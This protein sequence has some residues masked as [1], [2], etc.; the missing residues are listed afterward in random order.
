MNIKRQGVGMNRSAVAVLLFLFILSTTLPGAA[1]PLKIGNDVPLNNENPGTTEMGALF[2]DFSQTFMVRSEPLAQVVADLNNDSRPDVAVIY[3]DSKNLDIFFC[4]QNNNFSFTNRTS[5]T[6]TYDLTALTA[7]YMDDDDL[8]DLVVASNYTSNNVAILYQKNNFALASGTIF[9][10]NLRPHALV[11][12]DFDGDTHLDVVTLFSRDTTSYDPGF[13]IHFYSDGYGLGGVQINL[14]SLN[15]QM[16]RLMISGDFNGD[17]L[18]D[19]IIGDHGV[20]RVVGYING[21]PDGMSWTA[22]TSFNIGGP[23]DL[24]LE[25]IDGAGLL[26]LAVCADGDSQIKFYHFSS[27]SFALVTLITDELMP[28]SLAVIDH[29]GDSRLDVVR[30]STQY[31]N[32][33][34]FDT[35]ATYPY[36]YSSS[37]SFPTPYYPVDVQALDMNSD[38]ESDL[39]VI[40]RSSSGN[41]TVTIY[42]QNSITVSNANDNQLIKDV[43]PS[44]ATIGDFNGDGSNEVAVYD[45]SAAQ[46]KVRF[47]DGSS[48]NLEQRN[49]P[50]NVSYLRSTDL[51]GDGC[52]E[53]IMTVLTP[54]KAWVWFGSSTFMIGGGSQ[55]DITS[56]GLTQASSVTFG[57]LDNDTD[58][59]LA[60]GGTGGVD[61]FWS[62]GTGTLYSSSQHSF[63]AITGSSVTSITCGQLRAYNSAPDNLLDIALVNSTA[64]RIEIYY[65]QTG[66][67]KFVPIAHQYLGTLPTIGQVSSADLNFDGL[68]DLITSTNGMMHFYLQNLAYPNGFDEGQPVDTLSVPEGVG[69]FD[70]G[71][72]NDDGFMELAVATKNSVILAYEFD[73]TSFVMLTRQTAGASPLLLMADDMDDDLKADLVAYSIPSRTISSYYQNNFAPTASGHVDGSGHL[74]GD[75]VTFNASGS[76]DSITDLP[77]LNYT[78][79][80]GDGDAG[81]GVLCNHVY[82]SNQSYSVTLTVRDQGGLNDTTSFSVSIG[83]K[84]PTAGLECTSI[85]LIEGQAVQFTDLS[86]SYPDE[87]NNYT[88]NFGDNRTSFQQNP[89]H[90]YAGDGLYVVSLTVR[91]RDGSTDDTSISVTVNDSGPLALFNASLSSPNEG[92]A[93]HFEDLSSS[94]V[95]DIISWNWAFGDGGTS[96]LQ[97]PSRTY[98]NNGSY[99]V[100]LLITDSDGTNA[101]YNITITVL[102]TSPSILSLST[103][104]ASTS[105]LEYDNIT[106]MVK[107]QQAWDDID[108]YEWDFQMVTFSADVTTQDNSSYHQYL[109][110]GSY[111]MSVRVWDGDSYAEAYIMILITDPAPIA[112]YSF[113]IDPTTGNVTFSAALSSDT[114][115]DQPILQYRWNFEGT[116]S[117]WSTSNSTY[118][119]FSDGVYSV[120]L[121]VKDDHNSAVSKTRN[122][123][124]DLL[125]PV[126]SFDEPVL[127]G[128]VGQTIIIRA[129][130]TDVVGVDTVILEYTIDNVTRTVLMTLEGDSIYIGQIPAQNHTA[131][132]SY[133]I[134]AEDLS[135]H[136]STTAPL[137]ISVKYEDSSLFMLTSAVLLIALLILLIYLFLSRPIVDEVFVMYHDGTLLAHQTRRL[138]PGMD[139]EILGGMLIALQNFVRDSFKDENSTVL[140]RMDFG[141]RK[142]LVE[143]KDDFFLAVILSGKRAGGAPQRMLK[144]LDSIEDGYSEVLKEWDGD[145]EKVRGIREET[146]PMFQRANPLDRLKRKD[147]DSL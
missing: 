34:V 51:N 37:I 119:T 59:D 90:V 38:G 135:G 101:S 97:N 62:S 125:P 79:D 130:V 76:L 106:M 120:K 87:I 118:H 11:L 145:L 140:S 45:D 9:T 16:P 80:F 67:T 91:D 127:E 142:L 98:Q 27:G 75:P 25:Q 105:F 134:I 126:I 138:K 14:G 123:T 86:V 84:G 31:H 103:S 81:Y 2:D 64:S 96:T 65:Q 108:R 133:R 137:T 136:V 115:N 44:L 116:W 18:V 43:D 111:K 66:S 39:V 93:V 74:E 70:L 48:I 53:L 52:D 30:T 71:D 23:T 131:E 69:S 114:D 132:I 41:G 12:H 13:R 29:N 107:V 15:M 60:I 7:G 78:W 144:V 141:E 54:A 146:K 83:D 102:D 55:I 129:N 94:T 143:R 33:T 89:Q 19:L 32:I 26:E 8:M 36:G 72:L 100:T 104:T 17:G 6:L 82:L 95:D 121:E 68:D 139:D 63:L 85:S 24:L 88:W 122:V 109:S 117:S 47:L 92:Q 124:V 50:A 35:P 113:N 57:D 22:T 20:G 147:G 42:Y 3:V 49:A 28:S 110:A 5:V 73:G 4:D 56:S 10:T 58:V 128:T 99:L 46:P 61:V 40:S 1:A 21:A 77:I 112:D